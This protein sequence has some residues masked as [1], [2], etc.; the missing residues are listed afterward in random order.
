MPLKKTKIKN[1]KDNSGYCIQVVQIID[2]SG[3]F[4]GRKASY[5][6]IK[7][8]ILVEINIPT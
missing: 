3:F 7:L 4:H 8:N 6:I 1:K 2:Q 5:V